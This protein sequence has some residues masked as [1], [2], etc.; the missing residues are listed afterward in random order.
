MID[1]SLD[2]AADKKAL[3]QRGSKFAVCRSVTSLRI[4]ST[5]GTRQIGKLTSGD[6]EV[7]V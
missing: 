3:I 2:R 1:F 4:S 5:S 7:Y 6:N